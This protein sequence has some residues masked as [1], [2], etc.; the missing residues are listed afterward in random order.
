M[1]DES[2][3]RRT[4]LIISQVYVPDP[5]S[6]GQHMHDAAA[7]MAR[8]GHRVVVLTSNRGYDD[9]SQKY[10]AREMRD[11][12]EIRRLRLSSFGKKRMW[13]RFVAAWLFVL[14]CTFRG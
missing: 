14:Q 2:E 9:P 12:V 8:R 5:A 1:G 13:L 10:S 4:I 3:R 7:E 6:V 11:G